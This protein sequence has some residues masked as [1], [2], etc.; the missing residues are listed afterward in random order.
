MKT[1]TITNG[2][3]AAL[4]ATKAFAVAVPRQTEVEE[5]ADELTPTGDATPAQDDP[6]AYEPFFDLSL[7]N[8][9]DENAVT[10]SSYNTSGIIPVS[11]IGCTGVHLPAEDIKTVI[12]RTIQW[13][14]KGGQVPANGIHWD[15]TNHTG[16]YM[17]NCKWTWR[18]GAPRDELWEAYD[19]IVDAC[20]E[21]R[22]GWI[23]SRKWRKFYHITVMEK[24]FYTVPKMNLCPPLC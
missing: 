1:S 24:I 6:A 15:T 16:F 13:S 10:P 7:L 23:T 14:A 22:S 19:I 11:H 9:T 5:L 8:V 3:L 17:C 4:G 12:D 20:G 18:D 21:G 2:L